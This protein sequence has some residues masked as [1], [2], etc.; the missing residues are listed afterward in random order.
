MEENHL[1]DQ[2]QICHVQMHLGL[3]Y[4]I[5][6][7]VRLIYAYKIGVGPGHKCKGNRKPPRSQK[8]EDCVS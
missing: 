7:R 5:K 8:E 3:F 4:A 6:K 1:S 2:C